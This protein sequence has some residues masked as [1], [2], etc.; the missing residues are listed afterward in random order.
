MT[1]FE[2]Y[3]ALKHFPDQEVLKALP[4]L[5]P[6]ASLTDLARLA[7]LITGAATYVCWRQLHLSSHIARHAPLGAATSQQTPWIDFRPA[8]LIGAD[9]PLRGGF[10]LPIPITAPVPAAAAP[11]PLG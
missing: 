5:L 4:L 2:V 8:R 1:D 3:T 7:N 6:D 9:A 11:P 10:D